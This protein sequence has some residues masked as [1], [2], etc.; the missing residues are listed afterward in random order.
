M[1]ERL[2]H[3]TVL[4]LRDYL[5]SL[6]ENEVGAADWP[7]K[8]TSVLNPASTRPST[9]MIRHELQDMPHLPP[10]QRL[11]LWTEGLPDH[12]KGPRILFVY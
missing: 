6:I 12:N 5:T 8:T 2:D 4:E 11:P 7:V 3:P 1:T 9:I 10:K